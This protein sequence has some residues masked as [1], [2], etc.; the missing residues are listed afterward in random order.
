MSPDPR[1]ICWIVAGPNGAGKTTFA[2][3]YLPL[4]ANCRAFVNA[5]LI[6]AG[7]APLA[8]E[9]RK[10]AAGR[11]FLREIARHMSARQNFGFETTLSGR[12]HLKLV[13]RLKADGWRVELFYLALPSVEVARLRVAER[14]SHGGHDVP[15]PDIERRYFRSLDNLF[16][17]YASLVDRAVCFFNVGPSPSPIFTQEGEYRKVIELAI[18]G[19][20]EDGRQHGGPR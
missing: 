18:F 12:G 19:G 20:L 1:P 10:V 16:D 17:E 9:R 3:E 6:A 4:I 7:L 15:T 11:I 5:D 14:V 2:L 8:P 13:K